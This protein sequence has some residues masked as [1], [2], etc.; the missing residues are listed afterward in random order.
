M[1]YGSILPTASV[2]DCIRD[3]RTSKDVLK[4]A[5]QDLA[6]ALRFENRPIY[7]NPTYSAV[8]DPRLYAN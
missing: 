4:A 1:N 7:S 2:A 8:I 6:R 3:G 5:K